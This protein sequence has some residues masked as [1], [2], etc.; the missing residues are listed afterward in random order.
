MLKIILP[1]NAF[2]DDYILN[3]EFYKIA[4]VSKNA[5]NFW[6]KAQIATYQGSRTIFLR[7]KTLPKK[8]L[9]ATQKCADLSGFALASAFCS[10]TT[11]SPSHLVATNGSK[12]YDLL[13]I[14]EIC[15]VKLVNLRAF[16]DFLGLGYDKFIYIE[17][18]HFFSPAPLEKRIKI[19]PTL[20]VG[21]Y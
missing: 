13:E 15:G 20:C 10:F 12:I 7:K 19:T 21:Y 18:C 9:A 8:H 5:F 11:L 14:K 16:Y 6:S 2:L 4:G 3:V 1:P 17:K